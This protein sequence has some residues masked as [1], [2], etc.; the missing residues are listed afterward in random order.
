MEVED[1]TKELLTINMHRGIF[2]YTRLAYG[3]APAPA[4]FQRT[5]EQVMSGVPGTQVILDDMIVTGKTDQEHL[6]NL[7]LVFQ[8]LSENGLKANVEKCKF[9]KEKVTFCGHEIDR[10]GLHKMQSKIDAVMNAPKIENVEQLRSFLGL[11]QYYS[12]FLPNLSTILKPLH[13]LLVKGKK[14]K[15][16]QQCE[17][18]VNKV[19]QL[20]TSDIVLTH[21]NQ[22]DKEALSIV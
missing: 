15:W 17:D 18:A 11:V 8:R 21:Y 22:I 14:W 9:F 6:E 7:E 2:R 13:E 4:I 12:K 19:K 10:N 20:I 5:I 16:T 1:S 3:T